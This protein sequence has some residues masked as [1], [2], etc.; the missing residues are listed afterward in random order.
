M[1]KDKETVA[2]L[3]KKIETLDYQ[4]YVLN[5]PSISDEEYDGL[6]RELADL[7]AAHPELMSPDSPTQRVG[8]D[9]TKNFPTVRHIQPMMSL[10]NTYDESELK[11]FD[12]RVKSILD[13][14]NYEYV[15]ELKF[16][17]VAMSL[18]YKDGTLIRGVTRGDGDEGEEV[19]ANLKT[20]RSI[21]LKIDNPKY[22]DVEIR[23]EVLM[24]R[25]EFIQ[26]NAR[27]AEA[28]EMTFVNPRN[29]SAGTLKLQ[30]PREVALRPLKF[31]SYY[32]RE[33]LPA[34][35]IRSHFDSLNILKELRFPVMNVYQKCADIGEVFEFC[36]G[37]ESKREEL[38]FEIDGVVIKVNSFKQHDILGAT[39]KS[40]RWAIAFKFKAQQ[41][42]T[43]VKD[44]TLQVGR[45]GIVSPVAELDPV[46]LAGST[47]SRVTIHNEDF[48][49][50]KD[51]R[52][53]DF[54]VIEK[55]GDVIPK[56]VR[57]VLKKRKK[58]THPY[59]FPK[60]CPICNSPISKV[61]GEAAWRCDNL[62]CAAQVKRRI[63]HFA[64][65]N[66]MDIENC[67]E[68]IVH[69]LVEN[70]L[71]KDYADLY[72][73]SKES[74]LSL[75]RWGEK[76]SDNFLSGIEK[77]KKRSL[78]KLI[79][80]LGI[81]FVGE[82]SA[83]DLARRFKSLD[84]VMQASEEDLLQI[85]GIGER[86][87]KSVGAFFSNKAN[88]GVLQ[89]LIRAGIN[90]NHI[91][92]SVDKPPLLKG[93][94]FVL[95]GTLPT[96]GRGEAKKM[97]EDYGGKVSGSVSSKTNFLLSGEDAGSKLDK[98]RELKVTII[99]EEEFH[100]MIAHRN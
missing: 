36:K 64:S 15:C 78:E 61:D 89:K 6:L 28:G 32:L 42:E 11:D 49:R 4:Y 43:R 92:D 79:F 77:S 70:K 94:T 52:I 44:I 58:F 46:F 48:I 24:Y 97:I 55:G 57:V 18:I 90:V 51:I 76:S 98:A 69:Q 80:G 39:A 71:I 2:V 29:S 20:I 50:E 45:T 82:E 47:I 14:E 74:L 13:G 7:E 99:D 37:W 1:N 88:R 68:A 34:K 3:R 95:T 86:T 85:E 26:M 38:P 81:K 23:G 59:L 87:A 16:D 27:R 8:S 10:S 60:A 19:T 84:Q 17:G 9:L 33:L 83:K 22:A 67:G 40:P 25:D 41:V 35:N 91:S 31:F 66:A 5:S 93:I 96:L 62:S 54:V 75:E 12:R 63:E 100:K 65:R 21:P 73:L 56:I 72:Y 53:G 30:D